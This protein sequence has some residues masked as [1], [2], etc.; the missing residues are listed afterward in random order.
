MSKT[1]S[2]DS[3]LADYKNAASEGQKEI[4]FKE[5][6]SLCTRDDEIGR[7]ARQNVI[8]LSSEGDS[9]ALNTVRQVTA[10]ALVM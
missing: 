4:Y 3:L 1:K 7:K 6:R 9:R 2:P 5:L 8:S 10:R